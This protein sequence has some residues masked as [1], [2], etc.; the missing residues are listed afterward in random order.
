MK[1]GNTFS[2]H[3]KAL[4]FLFL[5]VILG[6]L[7]GMPPK[8]AADAPD[9]SGRLPE[10]YEEQRR[11]IARMMEDATVMV[12]TLGKRQAGSGSGF[13]VGDG[14]I[15][16]NAHV[17]HGERDMQYFIFN[18]KL[19]P[20]QARLVGK[21]YESNKA[22]GSDFALL[23]F[24][25]PAGLK[26]PV[27]ALNAD[28]Q[29]MDKVSAWGYP[30]I[31]T[32]FDQS[33]RDILSPGKKNFSPPP[34]VYTE[35]TVSALVRD[36]DKASIIHT[37]PIS[38]GNSGGPLINSRGEVVGINTWLYNDREYGT[39]I[40]AALPANKIIAFLEKNKVTPRL[41][42]TS[43]ARAPEADPA[44][45]GAEPPADKL[46]KLEADA[47]V[48]D[49]KALEYL[50]KA[51]KNDPRAMVQVGVM[52]LDGS[53]G[54]PKDLDKALYWLDRAAGVE[55]P[56]AQGILGMLFILES[57]IHDP[58][59]GLRLLRKSA[60]SPDGTADTRA[61]L[62]SVLYEGEHLGAA[63]DYKESFRWAKQAAEGGSAAGKGILAFH[64][65]DGVAVP[66][67]DN[68]AK[69]L[70]KEAAAA[71]DPK[72]KALLASYGRQS[73]GF[74]AN[75]APVLKLAREAAE[76]GEASAQGM[77]AR[78]YAFD[79]TLKDV[80]GSERW[81]RLAAGQA[82]PEG[83][84]VLGWLY[85]TGQ[86]V[87]KNNALAWAYLNLAGEKID[88]LNVDSRGPLLALLEKD[89]TAQEKADAKKIQKNWFSEWGLNV[90]K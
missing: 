16:T 18:D 82:N 70:A 67:D 66:V 26:L 36:R 34:V 2:R 32:Q 47:R 68:K 46:D 88:D 71:G 12:L 62:A 51:R 9:P 61:F 30:G 24:S 57:D 69:A 44:P 6:S 84:Y 35:G 83:Q 72:G 78:I 7:A 58:A 74:A 52:Y 86:V 90:L 1:S 54:Y 3:G 55:D 17:V 64:Y 41:P 23:K 8:A 65:Y 63:T 19:P 59:R 5:L 77:L 76:A 27:L 10:S 60:S 79:E 4:F 40:Y 31:V 20:T 48:K 80:N 11:A 75:P 13:V 42:E 45:G 14:L 43:R 33:T 38:G 89:M 87:E 81:A 39:V 25:P 28:V 85:M 50:A 53:R 56:T 49:A 21:A 15:M 29:R 73:D 37:A 22:G